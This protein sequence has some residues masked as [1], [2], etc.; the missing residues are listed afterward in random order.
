[1]QKPTLNDVPISEVLRQRYSPYAFADK[2]VD[3]AA[4]ASLF[5]A[6]RWSPELLQRAALELCHRPA[7]Q[8]PVRFRQAAGLPDARQPELGGGRAA[9]GLQRG[10]AGL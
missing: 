2:P 3:P 5:E 9:A 7:P 8:R 6:A 1:M 4:L 10:Q